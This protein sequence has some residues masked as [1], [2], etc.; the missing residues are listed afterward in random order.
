M[1]V[2]KQFEFHTSGWNYDITGHW[3]DY[4]VYISGNMIISI[5][6]GGAQQCTCL[7]TGQHPVHISGHSSILDTSLD[8]GQHPGVSGHSVV[9][10]S[11]MRQ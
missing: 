8:P 2:W 7:D 6:D 4:S 11:I 5:S 9:S 3:V 10:M 1:H